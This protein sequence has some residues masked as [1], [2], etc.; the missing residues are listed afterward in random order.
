M[1]GNRKAEELAI[2]LILSQPKQIK[3]VLNRPT[4]QYNVKSI[5]AMR[6]Q[7][8]SPWG[9]L[10]KIY[11]VALAV[12]VLSSHVIYST[13]LPTPFPNTRFS[14]DFVWLAQI[15][16]AMCL[17]VFITFV[18]LNVKYRFRRRR[19]IVVSASFLGFIS[20]FEGLFGWLSPELEALSWPTL[21]ISLIDDDRQDANQ[22][23]QNEIFFGAAQSF[24]MLGYFISGLWMVRD[25]RG[26]AFG[27]GQLSDLVKNGL[28]KAALPNYSYLGND[29]IEA[30]IEFTSRYQYLPAAIL[31]GTVLFHLAAGLG[32]FFTRIRKP[33]ALFAIFY[34]FIM[35]L[36]YKSTY[37]YSV[38]ALFALFLI[39]RKECS[40]RAV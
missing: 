18:A 33:W 9:R 21:F 24:V 31:L 3:T 25:L 7:L 30:I 4:V 19:G 39:P 37:I 17:L 34:Q 23:K 13:F 20:L 12:C 5:H 28:I 11:Y 14:S 1:N 27:N 2:S 26:V 10:A 40:A 6:P 35:M 29:F 32:I 16:A 22:D 8:D 38:A 36:P 15:A